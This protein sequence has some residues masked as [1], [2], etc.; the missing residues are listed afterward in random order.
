MIIRFYKL[1]IIRFYK[2]K[3]IIRFYKLKT[4]VG[5]QKYEPRFRANVQDT[6]L[7]HLFISTQIVLKTMRF[8]KTTSAQR[9]EHSHVRS[10]ALL[11]EGFGKM[12]KNQQK[13]LRSGKS[14]KSTA[15]CRSREKGASRRREQSMVSML[16]IH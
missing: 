3:M 8:E 1:I 9:Q 2:F 16:Q 10:R 5:S 7:Y 12:R 6:V 4:Q 13:K 14:Q 11:C 15:S